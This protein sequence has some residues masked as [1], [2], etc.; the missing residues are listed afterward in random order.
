MKELSSD[1]AMMFTESVIREMTRICIAHNGINL[2]QGFPDFQA[3]AEIKAAAAEAIEADYN[4]YSITWGAPVLRQAIARKFADYNGLRIDPET[5]GYGL[6]RIHGVD[7]L[8]SYGDCKSRR[9]GYCLRT[10]LRELRPRR[11]TERSRPALRYPS[12]T[13]LAF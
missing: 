11:H 13:G 3:P 12:R 4:Q 9:R 1:R 2:A 8:I 5:R 6:L 7:D 10:F